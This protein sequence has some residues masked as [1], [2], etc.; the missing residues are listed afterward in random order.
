MVTCDNF[1]KFIIDEDEDMDPAD[2]AARDE[3]ASG[4]TDCW[5]FMRGYKAYKTYTAEKRVQD[6]GKDAPWVRESVIRYAHED[7][8]RRRRAEK[9]LLERKLSRERAGR[10]RAAKERLERERAEQVQAELD[11]AEQARAAYG[12]AEAESA[13]SRSR[14]RSRALTLVSCGALA[15]G[16]R[17]AI[18]LLPAVDVATNSVARDPER[19]NDGTATLSTPG[20]DRGEVAPIRSRTRR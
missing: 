19:A 11:R 20:L 13:R 6:V 7:I 17:I 2:V 9:R 16:A 5:R 12:R 18:G 4:C 8:E 1:V 3:H 15:I 14:T 10:E